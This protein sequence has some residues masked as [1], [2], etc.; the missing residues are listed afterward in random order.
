MTP[1]RPALLLLTLAS[2]AT[3][4]PALADATKKP[5]AVRA[6]PASA[7]EAAGGRHLDEAIKVWRRALASNAS[8][9][10]TK[11]ISLVAEGYQAG[12]E[13][14]FLADAE[15]MAAEVYTTPV[16]QTIMARWNVEFY[17][18]FKASPQAVALDRQAKTL[19]G[20]RLS[21][22]G[23]VLADDGKQALQALSKRAAPRAKDAVGVVVRLAGSDQ[24]PDF[25]RASADLRR[26]LMPTVPVMLLPS[27]GADT[28]IHELGHALFGLADE[29]GSDHAG[30]PSA[31]VFE[32]YAHCPNVSDDADTTRWRHV[33]GAKVIE[34]GAGH[35]K[36]VYRPFA[37]CRMNESYSMNFCAFCQGYI[38][39]VMQSEHHSSDQ[40]QAGMRAFDLLDPASFKANVTGDKALLKS[41]PSQEVQGIHGVIPVKANQTF[42]LRWAAPRLL[43]K[44]WRVELL[45]GDGAPRVLRAKGTAT[46]LTIEGGLPARKDAA[47]APVKSYYWVMLY[48]DGY[49]RVQPFIAG[50]VRVD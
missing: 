42:T 7:P 47:G 28:L 11:R 22:A 26:P 13:R 44:G 9:R 16:G 6:M 39:A 45:G 36:G 2:L 33:P 12:E 30:A 40:M 38:E 32:D 48:M 10:T 24:N 3:L 1:M 18:V 19:F 21:G 5:R 27:G 8:G 31:A 34:G 20:T 35:A 50:I 25:V 29:Y 41:Y 15:R 37:S 23:F 4:S 14:L 43:P 46:A 49:A 17:Y